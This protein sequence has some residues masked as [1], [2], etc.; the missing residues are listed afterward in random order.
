MAQE[1]PPPALTL[2]NVNPPLTATGVGIIEPVE[3]L[4]SWDDQFA[5]QQYAVPVVVMAQVCCPPALIWLKRRPPA[6]GT[7]TVLQLP[8]PRSGSTGL[9]QGLSG[10]VVVPIPS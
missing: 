8:K 9:V 4:P 3:L 2:M 5:P 10:P 7:G 6:T 1:C